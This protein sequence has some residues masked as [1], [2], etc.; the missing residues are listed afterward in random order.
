MKSII[1]LVVTA[2]LLL[3]TKAFALKSPFPS[4]VPELTTPNSHYVDTEGRVLRSSTPKKKQIQ[5]LKDF[6]IEQ[7]IIFKKQTRKEVDREI[8]ELKAIG[9]KPSQIH[10]IPF[11]WKGFESRQ[12]A[13]EQTI[14]ALKIIQKQRTKASG[15]VFF[16][17]TVGEDRTGHLAGIFRMLD[18]GFSRDQAFQEEMCENGFGRGNPKKPWKVYGSIRKELTPLFLYMASLVEDGLIDLN[19][20]DESV[21]TDQREVLEATPKCQH[22]SKYPRP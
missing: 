22:S 12:V 10:H 2:S 11:R 6:D 15:K 4:T 8:K 14:Q 16:H 5:E 21:C 13:C 1:K 18:Q 17:C 9:Y 19:N 7:V 20:L 3:S